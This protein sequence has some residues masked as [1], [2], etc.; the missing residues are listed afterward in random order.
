MLLVKEMKRYFL[1]GFAAKTETEVVQ[2]YDMWSAT[3]DDQPDNLM[4]ALDEEIFSKLLDNVMLEGK[5]VADIGC[6][7][8]RHWQKLIDKHPAIIKG[9][10]VS[11][12]ML[13]KLQQKFPDAI[14]QQIFD[15]GYS[16]VEDASVDVIIST[17]TMAH[18]ENLKVSLSAWFRMLKPNGD[19]VLTDFHPVALANGG[20]RTFQ[21]AGKLVT[22][23]NFVYS[24]ESIKQ[25]AA[26]NGLIV[27]NEDE[28]CIS[29]EHKCFYEHKNALH[30]FEKF[31]GTPIIYGL[32]LRRSK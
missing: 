1:A 15:D 10:D 25:I 12:G 7:T 17:L 2:A 27:V 22:V 8:G 14:T 5:T 13:N 19:I 16:N 23:K 29:E 20:R 31:K 26:K 28:I 18:L 30:V 3:Y 21:Q 24:V 9:Y 4:L 32:H 6:G 11:E